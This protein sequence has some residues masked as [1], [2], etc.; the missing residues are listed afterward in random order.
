MIKMIDYEDYVVKYC[1]KHRISKEEAEKHMI[2]KLMKQY[3]GERDKG[4]VK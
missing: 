1:K 2:V 3:Y 4:K